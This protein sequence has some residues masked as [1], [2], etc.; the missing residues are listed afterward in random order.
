MSA[1]E[2]S[3]I[4]SLKRCFIEPQLE[5]SLV[6][7]ANVIVFFNERTYMRIV[8]A[9]LVYRGE[10]T[11]TG[12]T[13]TKSTMHAMHTSA[14]T[15]N[16][17]NAAT[18]SAAVS[19]REGARH[20]PPGVRIGIVGVGIVVDANLLNKLFEGVRAISGVFTRRENH[21]N[22]EASCASNMGE[23][24]GR[25]LRLVGDVNNFGLKPC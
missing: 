25:A 2:I 7:T 11:S 9:S 22:G 10:S 16:C 14:M 12:D 17:I 3:K 19:G 6:G 15:R 18:A 1:C 20:E 23:P 5:P 8:D 4:P 13:A 21:F 24:N